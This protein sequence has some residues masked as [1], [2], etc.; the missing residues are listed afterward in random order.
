MPALSAGL[1]LGAFVSSSG[2][3]YT[4][5][6]EDL[7]DDGESGLTARSDL[8][9][10]PPEGRTVLAL[11]LCPVAG[12][13]YLALAEG[14]A[15]V[16]SVP[17]SGGNADRVI[18]VN[19]GSGTVYDSMP[20]GPWRQVY[21]FQWSADGTELFVKGRPAAV[22]EVG[23]AGARV[24]W[25][26]GGLGAG[27]EAAREPLLAPDFSRVAYSLWSSVDEEDLW[28]LDRGPGAA[29]PVR[30][31]TG[32]VGGYPV[33]WLGGAADGSEPQ[34][35]RYILVTLGAIS[36]G[37]GTPSGLAVA[38]AASGRLDV[39]YPEGLTAFRA[40]LV[41]PGGRSA[42]VWS[43]NSMTGEGGRVFW[44]DPGTGV[45]TPV[46]ALDG[47]RVCGR[48]AAVGDGKAV[49]LLSRVD[50]P[51]Y[52]VWWTAGDGSAGRVGT[53]EGDVNAYLLGEVGGRAFVLTTPSR[54]VEG[55]PPA[56]LHAVDVAAGAILKVEFV[57]E[58]Q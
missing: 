39:W 4:W 54:L 40:V 5:A 17:G 37:G 34:G 13:P 24:S 23:P 52:E 36:T 9:Y 1:G 7:K 19:L 14:P 26:L 15:A 21:D 32:N 28:V 31:T 35:A 47:L 49:V 53:I 55:E 48:A 27:G 2:A 58:I 57:A 38:D 6:V 25:D 11:S 10:T 30:L 22:L 51:G 33:A 50:S 56:T 41:D 42:L 18:I 45:E 20:N 43:F 3:V 16:G 8:V 44:R 29:A 12:R 46:P